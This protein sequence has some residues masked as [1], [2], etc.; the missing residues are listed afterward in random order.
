M[1]PFDTD[2]RLAADSFLI[3]RLP[4]CDLRLMNDARWPWLILVPRRPG[5]SELHDLVAQDLATVAAETA[6]ISQRLKQTCDALKVNT[7]ALGNMVRQLHVHV[8]ARK[9]GDPGWP[10]PVWGFGQRQ[11]YGEAEMAATIA[12]ILSHLPEAETIR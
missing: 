4:F 1:Q 3:G 11:P 6:L 9:E 2:A 7:G 10:G 12:K 8:V 5:L